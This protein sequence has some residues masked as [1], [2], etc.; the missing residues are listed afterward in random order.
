MG[1]GRDDGQVFPALMGHAH[2]ER[3]F[4]FGLS[5]PATVYAAGTG[6]ASCA[7]IR[8]IESLDSLMSRLLPSAFARRVVSNHV[9]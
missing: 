5:I 2:P 4:T 7:S 8:K 3:D 9:F 1:T 6:F